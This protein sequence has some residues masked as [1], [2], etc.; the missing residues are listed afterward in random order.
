MIFG[1]DCND[2]NNWIPACAG[3]TDKYIGMTLK[4]MGVLSSLF[5]SKADG[6]I[7]ELNEVLT[8]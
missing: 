6:I 1:E 4:N 8:V 7:K 5:V 3:M 2:C